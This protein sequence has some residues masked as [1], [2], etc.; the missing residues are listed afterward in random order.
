MSD[1]VPNEAMNHTPAVVGYR[2]NHLPNEPPLREMTMQHAKE[3]PPDETRDRECMTWGPRDPR[4]TTPASAGMVKQNDNLPNKPAQLP[5]GNDDGTR[6]N[7]TCQMKHTNDDRPD[8]TQESTTH[9]PKWVCGNFKPWTNP[10]PASA[11]ILLNPHPPTEAT[12]PPSEN[13][14]PWVRGNPNGEARNN[15]PWYHTPTQYHTPTRVEYH[16]PEWNKTWD[17]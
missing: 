7:N 14:Q 10:T 13:T 12:T 2:L 4:R 16:T 3:H 9:L 17:S 6:Q 8:Q 11:G 15:V 1:N 5:P